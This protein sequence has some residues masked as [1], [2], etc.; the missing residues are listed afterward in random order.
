MGDWGEW[1]VASGEWR[2]FPVSVR[3]ATRWFRYGAEL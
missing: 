2:V 1:L 3:F